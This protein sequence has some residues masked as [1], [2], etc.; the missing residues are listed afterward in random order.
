MATLD[1]NKYKIA[2]STI[3]LSKYK[4][5][6]EPTSNPIK[7]ANPFGTTSANGNIG[8]YIA[9]TFK[10]GVDQ[11]VA[12]YNTAANAPLSRPLD[13]LTGSTK[14]LAGGIGA[15]TSPLAPIFAPVGAAINKAGEGYGSL[16]AVQRLA[17]SPAGDALYKAADFTNDLS[18]VA[19]TIAPFAGPKKAPVAKPPKATTPAPAH[20]LVSKRLAE[21]DRIEANNAVVRRTTTKAKSQGIDSKR[22]LAETDLLH[23]AVD[24]TG[25]I[26]T[27]NAIQELNDFIRPYEKTISQS[28]QQEGTKIPLK[29][30]KNRIYRNIN[31]SGLE[32][33]ALENAFSKA[34]AEIKGLSRRADAQGNITLG[35]V[36]DA[37]I[38]K[39]STIDYLNPASKAADK[40]I[41][42]GLKELVEDNAKSV[43]VR[44]L[45]RELQQHFSVLNL[46]EKLDGKK[47]DG[48]KLGKYFAQTVG[49]IVGSHFGPLGAI[50]GAE[51]G[52]RIKGAALSNKLRGRTGASLEAS[53]TMR[54]AQENVQSINEGSRNTSQ[55]PT[56][57]TTP[58]PSIIPATVR[59]STNPATPISP[60]SSRILNFVQDTVKDIK[61]NGQRGFAKNPFY[62]GPT[63]PKKPGQGAGGAK[64]G[65]SPKPTTPKMTSAEF[66][67]Y[68]QRNVSDGLAKWE[69]KGDLETQLAN[70]NTNLRLLELQAKDMKGE[71]LTPA[72]VLEAVGLLRN[73]GIET[74]PGVVTPI[75]NTDNTRLAGS[76]AGKTWTGT[77]SS[78]QSTATN[79]S[80]NNA[81]LGKGGVSGQ[82][83]DTSGDFDGVKVYR[84]PHGAEIDPTKFT[85]DSVL[86]KV[87]FFA[88]KESNAKMYGGA[89]KEAFVDIQRPYVISERA[90][91]LG[92]KGEDQ[93]KIVR[94]MGGTKA[95]RQYLK[96]NGYDGIII[97]KDYGKEILALDPKQI[98]VSSP[99]I[100][101][102]L[103]PLA[104]EARKYK[105]AEEFVKGQTRRTVDMKDGHIAPS[106]DDTPVK[107]RMNDGGDFSLLEV[108]KGQHIQPADYFDPQRGPRMYSYDNAAGRESLAAI[109][110]IVRA[111]NAG[112]LKGKTVTVY[113]T[114]PK[115]LTGDTIA[116]GEWITFSKSYA[117]QHGLHRF[118]EGEYK[119]VSKEVEPRNLWWDGNDINEWGYDTGKELSK[120]QLTDF[121]NKVKGSNNK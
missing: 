44:A 86:G 114:V 76:T 31:R 118:G 8:T 36:H 27:Q 52:G 17:M 13:L 115:S 46:L 103:E 66:K 45:N 89:V 75:R 73:E 102:E 100:P 33:A 98:K 55:S 40:A 82:K 59:S 19:G 22:L 74:I 12:G 101:K 39:Y 109:N 20:P 16:N 81:P 58:K 41:A 92:G 80:T 61:K 105:S 26:R 50:A 6:A 93:V 21:L 108:A 32:G 85:N 47:V 53:E 10:G 15:L 78:K 25:T 29:T 63:P 34:S 30:V 54:R 4:V 7:G 65:S 2:S 69:A 99:S 72:E 111:T 5:V 83:T 49:T 48:G 119:I 112:T 77:K 23:G 90:K 14:M 110:N 56:N 62:K 18:I 42:R 106:F 51:I 91:S 68:V 104:A 95:F 1:L 88:D 28:L 87:M 64:G 57:T 35:K 94:D 11:A 70:S 38:N 3:D 97:E 71:P 9:D 79:T 120:S 121:Y 117:K 67:D 60:A 84:T 37:K 107:T 113:R 96:D 24:D 43:D 116:N